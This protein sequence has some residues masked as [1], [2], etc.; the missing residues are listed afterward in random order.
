VA[1]RSLLDVD[2]LTPEELARVLDRAVGFREALPPRD[3]LAGVPVLNLFFEASTRTATSFTLAEQR[4]GADI[5]S[6]APGASSLGKGETIADT[7]LT[8]C[9]IGVRAIVVRHPESGFARRLADAFDGNVINAGDGT[10]AHPTQALL[11]LMT[12]RQE[13]G[14]FEGLRVAIVG[15]ILHSRVARS[16][17]V[18]MRML[19]INVTLVGPTTLLPDAFARAGVRIERDLDALL[20]KLDAVMMLRIQRERISAGLLPALE[21]YTQRYQ[22]NRVRLGLLPDD[23]VILHPGPYNRGVELT[24]D[25]LDDPR[26]RYVAQV[27]NG[28]F[29]RM[30]VLDFLVNGVPVAV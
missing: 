20:P 25:V 22:L 13:F 21:D 28:V 4:V 12:L 16:N 17:I 27:H 8:L 11:D 5:I 30:A 15:D 10:H 18:G 19:G 29:V 3:L 7:A 14:R 24:D 2:D 1:P 26:S 23:A 6:F 9:S